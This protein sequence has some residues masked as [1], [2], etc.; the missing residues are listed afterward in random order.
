[1]EEF[2]QAPQK[3]DLV[4]TDMSMPDICGDEVAKRMQERRPDIP[5][6][7]C[8]GFSDTFSEK[9]AEACGIKAYLRKPVTSI[10]LLTTVRSAI[11]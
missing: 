10:E 1:M 5:I 4:I 3:Y 6:I 2:F 11:D 9:D 8:T 7:I